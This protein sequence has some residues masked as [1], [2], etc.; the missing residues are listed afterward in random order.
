MARAEMINP[1]LIIH[2]AEVPLDKLKDY[3][4]FRVLEFITGFGAEEGSGSDCGLYQS[5]GKRL[6]KEDIYIWKY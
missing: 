6:D 5:N 1:D 3:K 4:C 2:T